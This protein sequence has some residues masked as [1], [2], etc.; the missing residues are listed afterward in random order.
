VETELELGAHYHEAG[1]AFMRRRLGYEVA[2]AQISENRSECFVRAKQ[3]TGGLKCDLDGLICACSG[4]AAESIAGVCDEAERL[5]SKDYTRGLQIAKRLSGDDDQAAELLMDWA[6][7]M[8]EVILSA[9]REKVERLS[10]A[11]LTRRRITGDEIR[12]LLGS[13]RNGSD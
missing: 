3:G 7:R 4:Y 1:H 10:H 8:A 6:R 9:H 5:S 13:N 2:F 11:L 12:E